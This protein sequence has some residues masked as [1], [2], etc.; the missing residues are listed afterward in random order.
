MMGLG[1]D[2]NLVHLIDFG[3]TRSFINPTNGKHIDFVSG[4]NLVGT[5][6]YVSVNAHL[7]LELS[8]RDDLLTLG[9]VILYLYKGKLPWQ[10]LKIS[11]NSRNFK[12]LG[13]LK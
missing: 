5:C 8:R 4:K 7:G 11:K 10:H 1:E 9:N 12:T 3:L 2:S 13:K 6:R